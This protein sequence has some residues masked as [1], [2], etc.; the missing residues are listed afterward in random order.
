MPRRGG[1][2]ARNSAT[3][4][5]GRAAGAPLTR[6]RGGAAVPEAPKVPRRGGGKNSVPVYLIK[7]TEFHHYKE[8][9]HVI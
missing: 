4:D 1:E 3:C 7:G 9:R 6:E 5:V 2:G 8:N